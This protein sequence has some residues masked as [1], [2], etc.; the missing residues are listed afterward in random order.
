M[1]FKGHSLHSGKLLFVSISRENHWNWSLVQGPPDTI[2][3]WTRLATAQQLRNT[4]PK[5]WADITRDIQTSWG[6]EHAWFMV[7]RITPAMQDILKNQGV[8]IKILLSWK[9]VTQIK[10]SSKDSR[11]LWCVYPH[12]TLHPSLQPHILSVA[13]KV[14]TY[15]RL[16]IPT[17]FC[18]LGKMTSSF[19]CQ[20][21]IGLICVA[22]TLDAI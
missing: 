7:M 16:S 22:W 11:F 10:L 20:S 13:S 3:Q 21:R 17:H 6:C 14:A 12:F 18:E 1:P 8:C 15:C 2:S 9:C 19:V 4:G 5:R